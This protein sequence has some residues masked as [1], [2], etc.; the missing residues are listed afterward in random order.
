MSIV[1]YIQG[2]T[3]KREKDESDSWV[4]YLSTGILKTTVVLSAV[5]FANT[6]LD[7]PS[8]KVKRPDVLRKSCV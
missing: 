6:I 4:A 7:V 8:F 5:A 2:R 1:T 3:R